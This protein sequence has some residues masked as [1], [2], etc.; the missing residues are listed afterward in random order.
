MKYEGW[1][2]IGCCNMAH[3]FNP[4]GKGIRSSCNK[5]TIY[6]YGMFNGIEERH[7]RCPEC[8]VYATLEGK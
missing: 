4:K 7:K 8:M 3:W 6:H 5:W 2:F 1:W